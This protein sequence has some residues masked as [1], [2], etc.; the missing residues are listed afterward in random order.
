MTTPVQALDRLRRA[1]AS[2]ALEALADRFGLDLVVVFGSTAKGAPQPRDLDIAVSSR[3]GRKLA[4]L[5]VYEAFTAI[6]GP[7]DI[8]VMVLDRADPVA[9]YEALLGTIPLYERTPVRYFEVRMAA[10]KQYAETAPMRARS[11][12]LMA[13]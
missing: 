3:G 5:E 10:L 11:L 6:T 4:L 9:R 8:D 7:C 12:E 13:E 1:A 2:G